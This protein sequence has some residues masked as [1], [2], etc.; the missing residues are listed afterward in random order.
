MCFLKNRI[1]LINLLKRYAFVVSEG[2]GQGHGK[3]EQW[4]EIYGSSESEQ[5]PTHTHTYTHE[6]RERE[7]E[8]KQK[9]ERLEGK[10]GEGGQCE[11]GGFLSQ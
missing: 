11:I 8:R 10:S 6:Q 4:G 1:I 9:G 5:T 7:S 3:W 2:Q